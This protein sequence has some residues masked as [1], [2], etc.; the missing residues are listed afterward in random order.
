MQNKK[1]NKKQN[2]VSKNT[3]KHTLIKQ[4]TLLAFTLFSFSGIP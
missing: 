4:K 3:K 2:T 1:K